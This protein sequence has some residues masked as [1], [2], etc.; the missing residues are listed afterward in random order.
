[1]NGEEKAKPK[2]GS[3]FR[4]P[5]SLRR[6]RGGWVLAGLFLLAAIA[7][8]VL[9]PP[10]PQEE[11]P[12]AELVPSDALFYAGFSDHRALEVMAKKFP[13]AWTHQAREGFRTA[14]P[15]LAGGVAF[16]VDRE[17]EWVG[18]ARVKHAF[19]LLAGWSM[20]G[21]AVIFAQSP[22][23]LERQRRRLNSLL[24]NEA[25]RTLRSRFYL[26][27]EAL[28]PP[29]RLR[30]FSSLGF[31]LEAGPPLLL[32][33][34]LAYRPDRLRLFA[35]EYVHAPRHADPGGPAPAEAL[36]LENFPRLWEEVLGELPTEDRELALKEAAA[37][38]HDTLGGHPLPEFLKE[39]GPDW[40]LSIVPTRYGF[41]AAVAWI[42]LPRDGTAPTLR[43]LLEKVEGDLGGLARRQGKAPAFEVVPEEGRRNIQ[44]P[45][46]P[47]LRMGRA[48]APA[49]EI[50]AHR[51]VF[52]TCAETM[53]APEAPP[54]E[55]HAAG[56]I[57]VAPLLG[58]VRELAPLLAD[59]EFRPEAGRAAEAMFSKA[60]PASAMAEL[61][62]RI[63][64]PSLR[65]E[66]LA[67]EASEMYAR[68]LDE[69]S[70]TPRYQD[71]LHRARDRIDVWA[72]RLEWLRR[73]TFSGRFTGQG[74]E[75]EVRGWPQ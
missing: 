55:F 37:L 71:G 16:Y 38:A 6:R 23:A 18:L 33:G 64:D 63:P 35:E 60:H 9:F 48:F 65:E 44:F 41:P 39:L 69:L 25:F 7:W 17:F 68:A 36:L 5:P 30:D 29:G 62:R 47:T 70:K 40:G 74:L 57:E 12:L 22:A 27:I 56:T 43:R 2:P 72:S 58:S 21:D 19:P 32:R 51:I 53:S 52:T 34:R 11:F 13:H 1:M 46:A 66:T 26:N 42:D 24:D 31:E 10:R 3:F 61:L 67:L 8:A 50:R 20:E 54:G 28:K 45:W 14:R 49:Y 15:H 75:F 59:A 73:L 4:I